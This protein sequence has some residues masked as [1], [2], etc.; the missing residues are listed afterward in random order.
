M[1]TRERMEHF[2]DPALRFNGRNGRAPNY[3]PCPVLPSACAV[4]SVLHR[5]VE[6]TTQSR[7]WSVRRCGGEDLQL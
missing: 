4:S 7:L 5:P 1:V 6:C 3:A 2:S